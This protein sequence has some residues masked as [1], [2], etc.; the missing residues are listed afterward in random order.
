MQSVAQAVD[1]LNILA[2]SLGAIL[3]A[4]IAFLP[5]WLSATLV[6][7]ATGILMLVIFKF[8]SNQR[9][10]KRARDHIKVNLLALSLFKDSMAVS[11]RAQM[12]IVASAL[13][14]ALLAVVQCW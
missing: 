12:R 9:A 8:T 10:I 7:A 4:P 2:N 5:G 6:A 14:L 13:H 1:W 11:L 3:L